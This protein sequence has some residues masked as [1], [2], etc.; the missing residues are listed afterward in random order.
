[1]P[2]GVGDLAAPTGDLFE[3]VKPASAVFLGVQ[4]RDR[5]IGNSHFATVP[6]RFGQVNGRL[7]GWGFGVEIRS[8]NGVTIC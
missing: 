7:T 6:G 2:N 3:R 5:R 1:M 4:Q 8:C